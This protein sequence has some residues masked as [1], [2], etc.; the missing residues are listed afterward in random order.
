MNVFFWYHQR[1]M[2]NAMVQNQWVEAESHTRSLL[3]KQGPSMGLEY[4]L[5]VVL[6]G[7]ERFEEASRTLFLAIERYGESLR[8]CRLLAD[9]QYVRGNRN[10]AIQWYQKTLDDNPQGKELHLVTARLDLLLDETRFHRI[11]ETLQG[12]GEAREQLEKNPQRAFV[13]YQAIAEADPTHVEALNNLGTLYL[14]SF[15]NPLAAVEAFS[16]VLALVDNPGAARNLA[17]AKKEAKV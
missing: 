9:I 1:R 2:L 11:Q 17:K 12:I 7:Q 14:N 13:L 16:Q 10:E 3:D 4:N 8:L 5:A 6:L 15:N